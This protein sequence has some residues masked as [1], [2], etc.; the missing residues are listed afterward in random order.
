MGVDSEEVLG[1]MAL[2]DYPNL[3]NVDQAEWE[4]WLQENYQCKKASV[5]KCLSSSNWYQ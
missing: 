2:F 1:H 5:E 4:N 3:R